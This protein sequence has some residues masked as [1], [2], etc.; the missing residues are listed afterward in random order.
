MNNEKHMYVIKT[1]EKSLSF[2]SLHSDLSTFTCMR[3]KALVYFHDIC[4]DNC[5]RQAKG[6]CRIQWKQNAATAPDS[7]QIDTADVPTQAA[8]ATNAFTVCP[9]GYVE[10]PSGSANGQSPITPT[11]N[12][13]GFQSV[14]C[15]GVLGYTPPSSVGNTIVCKKRLHL[16]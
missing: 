8:G 11:F 14:Y 16:I 2:S 3:A 9:L 6:Y 15:G 12:P 10:I 7:F 1:S 4:L 5:I 13:L